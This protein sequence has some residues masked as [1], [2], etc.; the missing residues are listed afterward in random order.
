MSHRDEAAAILQREL[1]MCEVTV[2]RASY[3][4]DVC[5]AVARLRG[6]EAQASEDFDPMEV[7]AGGGPEIAQ[8]IYRKL[9]Q[10]ELR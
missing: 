3:D 6:G 4:R 2:E 9:R 1:P 10:L 8:S 5:R 7:L